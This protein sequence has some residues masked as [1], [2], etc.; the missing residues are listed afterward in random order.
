[1]LVFLGVIA[2]LDIAYLGRIAQLEAVESAPEQASGP[3]AAL[4]SVASLRIGLYRAVF[5]HSVLIQGIGSGLLAGKLAENEILGGLKYSIV[6]VILST[7]VF[8]VI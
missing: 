7:I 2:V 4:S 6:L 1:M 5:F 8:L 3:G